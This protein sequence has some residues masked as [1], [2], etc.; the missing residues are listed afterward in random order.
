MLKL[1]GLLRFIMIPMEGITKFGAE[2][3]GRNI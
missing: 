2:T 1:E 3:E